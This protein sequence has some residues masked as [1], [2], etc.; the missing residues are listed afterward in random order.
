MLV[1]VLSK[2]AICMYACAQGHNLTV[3]YIQAVKLDL[4]E[5]MFRSEVFSMLKVRFGADR[6]DDGNHNSGG[7]GDGDA[8]D[9]LDAMVQHVAAKYDGTRTEA[10]LLRLAQRCS[11]DRSQSA[12]AICTVRAAHAVAYPNVHRALFV[13][14]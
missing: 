8:D 7:D 6:H 11:D 13:C 9:L 5:K 4:Q 3:R 1:R 14:T 12:Y 2:S 10:M